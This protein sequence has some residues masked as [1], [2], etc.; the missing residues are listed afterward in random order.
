MRKN[1]LS[2]LSTGFVLYIIS[3]CNGVPVPKPKGYFR[4]EFPAHEYRSF[5]Q[6]GYPYSF[7]Y[8]V[9][10]NIIKDS[11][12][13][14]EQPEN[15]YW[16]NVDFPELHG[17]IYLSYINIG[18]RAVYKVKGSSGDYHDS[19]GVNTFDKL[20]NDAFNL[21]NRHA[22]KATSIDQYAVSSRPGVTGFIFEVGGN[23]ATRYQFYLTDS[24][25]HFLRGALYFDVPPNE[26][27]LK[28][29][30]RFIFEDL[31]HLIGTLRWK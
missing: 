18:T 1:F 3:S 17:R 6:A 2:L 19:T 14:D 27:S 21:T 7:D 12:Y 15:P 28:P 9:Y 4:I 13:F 5:E 20:I 8:P 29:V 24:V 16:I 10:A 23:A 26:D 22:E 11:S 30:N 31:K 25:K